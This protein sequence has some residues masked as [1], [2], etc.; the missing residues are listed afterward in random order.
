[1]AEPQDQASERAQERPVSEAQADCIEVL[2]SDHRDVKRLFNAYLAAGDPAVVEEL[3]DM[4]EVH[5]R[6]ERTYFYPDLAAEGGDDARELVEDGKVEH[7]A[8]LEI[9]GE[10]RTLNGS[11]PEFSEMVAWLQEQVLHHIQE[12][13]G[14][15]FSVAR[16]CMAPEKRRHIGEQ[17]LDL[18]RRAAKAH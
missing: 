14:E 1:M 9:I 10:L 8:M 6:A 3:C 15:M 2:A 12:E 13:E 5:D 4:L 16:Q 18:K 7:Q 11:E 17:I